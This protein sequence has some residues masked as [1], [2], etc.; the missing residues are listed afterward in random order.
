MA[1]GSADLAVAPHHLGTGAAL[2]IMEA[3]GNAV[4]GAIAANAVLGVVLPDTCGIG[5]DLFALVHRP[6]DQ[7][8]FALNSSGRAGA[9]MD[10]AA[11]RREG[12]RRMPLHSPWSVT[13]PGCVDGWE[14]LLARF[15]RMR[16]ADILGPAIRHAG[17]G[18]EASPELCASLA[19]VQDRLAGQESAPPL[20]PGGRPP[21]PGQSLS[22]PGLALTL[23]ELA[24]GGR[25]AFYAG[26]P[27]AAIGGATEGRIT[28]TDLNRRSAEWVEPIGIDLFECQAW[29]IPPNSQGYLT[30]AAAWLLERLGVPS[31]P[32][33]AGYHH[34]VIEAYRAVSWERDEL[35]ADPDFAPLP[36]QRLLDPERLGS[37]LERIRIDRPASWPP[38]HAVP[39]GTA[40]V[41]TADGEGMGVSLIQSNFTG[42]GSGLSAGDTGVF[43]QNRGAGFSLLPGHPNEAAPGKRPLHTLAPTLWTRRR[44]LALLLG[45]RGGHQQPQ[46]LLQVIAHL[47]RLGFDPAEAQALPRW[48]MDHDR[49]ATT[50]PIRIEGG[51][52]GVVVR[53]LAD[54]GHPVEV[55]PDR[56]LPGWGPVSLIRVE[57]D[58]HRTG[59][60]DPRISTATAE[61]R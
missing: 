22:R 51:M 48:T 50:S 46:L 10:A 16:L 33:D 52:P 27:G 25:E 41:C 12:H 2:D 49:T 3:G 60:A 9:G 59:A 29:T 56:H 5:G 42:I 8:P 7:R 36:A 44:A 57:D 38:A 61:A 14:A 55:V 18:F 37:R 35:V 30:L 6:G 31:D 43:L 21:E 53:R 34:A 20:Y 40:Y 45:T 32:E 26:R 47:F 39:G 15:G 13:I 58:G 54:L 28:T 19:R 23:S 17:D 1:T 4:D 24:Q 11:I